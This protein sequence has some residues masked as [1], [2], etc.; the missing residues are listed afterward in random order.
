M[1]NSNSL[2]SNFSSSDENCVLKSVQGR[3]SIRTED[4]E[5]SERK[6]LVLPK[7][8]DRSI[9]EPRNYSSSYVNNLPSTSSRLNTI[10]EI[11]DGKRKLDN[12]N[13]DD[14]EDIGS[15]EDEE[16]E[17]DSILLSKSNSQLN[18]SDLE[19]DATS[20]YAPTPTPI[21]NVHNTRRINSET[22]L[23]ES[24]RRMSGFMGNRSKRFCA[25]TSE[26]SFASHL[27]T[28]KSLFSPKNNQNALSRQSFNSSLYGSNISLNSTNSRLF[29]ANSPFYN[30]KTMFGGASAYPVRD[31]NQHKI[32]RNPVQM[33]PSSSLS[34]SSINSATSDNTP[35]SN[36]AKRI[37]E[38]MNQF[39]TP[40]KE[41][42]CMGNNI[43]SIL[44]IPSLVQNRQ[45]FGEDELN[46]NRSIAL[47]R[48]S[49]PYSR[50]LNQ[51]KNRTQSPLNSSI[52]KPLQIPTMSQLLQM[53]RLQNN[54]ERVR[55]IANKSESFLNKNLEYKLPSVTEETL[56]SS[57]S[58]SYKI[59]NNITK[60]ILRS[61]KKVDHDEIPLLNLPNIQLPVMKSVPKFDIKLI[62]EKVTSTMTSNTNLSPITPLP[63][64]KFSY[65][66][67]LLT[68]TSNS[69]KTTNA[70][71]SNNQFNF[72]R[73]I[74]LDSH[75]MTNH[76]QL[77]SVQQTF[78]FSKPTTLNLDTRKTNVSA[79]V[80][81]EKPSTTNSDNLF[82]KLVAQQQ[83]QWECDACMSRNDSALLKC[84]SCETPKQGTQIQVA[85][86]GNSPESDDLFK[87][88]AAQQ[89][90]TNWECDSCMT[91]NDAN[92][93]KCMC[94][95]TPKPGSIV[96]SSIGVP[97]K[98][99]SFGMPK[100]NQ[101]DLF[102]NLA[103]KQKSTQWECDSCLTGNDA[104]KD[105]CLCCNAQKPGT[106]HSVAVAKTNS[107]SFGMP[108][109]KEIN[110]SPKFSFGVPSENVKKAA[111]DA[112]FKSLLVKQ[113]ANW[114]CTACFTRNDQLKLKCVCCEQQKP[115]SATETTSQFS[116]GSKSS[117]II[118]PVASEVKFSFGMPVVKTPVDPNK[119]SSG[120]VINN[121]VHTVDVSDGNIIAASIRNSIPA[122]PIPTFSFKTPTS[123]S[124]EDSA[125]FLFKTPVNDA[126]KDNVLKVMSQN[127]IENVL[128]AIQ[129]EKNNAV[130]DDEKRIFES[131]S[132]L[133]SDSKS[134]GTI[135]LVDDPIV[136]KLDS[137][138]F[139][140]GSKPTIPI[141]S[142]NKNGG[143]SFGS[144]TATSETPTKSSVAAITPQALPLNS[145]GFSFSSN[146]SPMPTKI[147][148]SPIVFGNNSLT[149]QLSKS[150]VGA[151]STITT[152]PTS[153]TFTFG[154][155]SKDTSEHSK[156]F[157]SYESSRS[158]GNT[159]AAKLTSFSSTQTNAFGKESNDTIFSFSNSKNSEP[160]TASA[161]TVGAF[162]FGGENKTS[163]PAAGNLMLFG[164]GNAQTTLQS[165]TPVFGANTASAIFG[166]YGATSAP[167]SNI[168]NNNE[169]GF[170][171]KMP[172]FGSSF[173]NTNNNP[174]QTNSRK[175]AF[176]F[177][178]SEDPS[179]KKKNPS[180]EF[181]SQSA[182]QPQQ[183]NTAP[184][185]FGVPRGENKPAFNFTAVPSF[186]FGN[187]VTTNVNS[188][189][190]Q[191]QSTNAPEPFQ[192]GAIPGPVQPGVQT[193]TSQTGNGAAQTARRK[194]RANRRLPPR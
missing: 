125:S 81:S 33:R 25:S 101:D 170:G 149:Q 69:L 185:Q 22:N 51:S 96:A 95:E 134:H 41:A 166:T 178:M 140:F 2:E 43:N 182:H 186:N 181:S 112:G 174:P 56:A 148:T 175:P 18:E 114:E 36:T 109:S 66:S 31:I 8:E 105:R 57:S 136:K 121:I 162:T 73:P 103:A 63:T 188:S 113:N 164:S 168:N 97:V 151:S 84:L 144:F 39:S 90:K 49:A 48:P 139:L 123:S 55:E 35:L 13:M 15:V 75:Q 124:N 159:D 127:S 85:V 79:T 119:A 156:T 71:K 50:P 179:A 68:T 177:G 165:V 7:H 163:E 126:P 180:F 64:V 92:K 143:F 91:Q 133:S 138:G 54:T 111:L 26:L 171:S 34:N 117:G 169:S 72:S 82:K 88:L 40:L 176:Q 99:F 193:F 150:N 102:K 45:R 135:A 108:T 23:N 74:A 4:F 189:D 167:I 154:G 20:S 86:T 28:H 107:F 46:L 98:T 58:S 187:N 1:R 6:N 116:F 37:L 110:E 142:L 132:I 155:G 83:V 24:Q 5:I 60:K 141:T 145:S 152:M 157:D 153:S 17:N 80:Q 161:S 100:T 192:F 10:K 130:F 129:F 67:S 42:R 89:K 29:M 147:T 190:V 76:S 27:D 118:L 173:G 21:H 65:G 9:S 128:P 3:R 19:I 32:L 104:S 61:D 131:K 14:A 94:C 59:K 44:K 77:K 191:L 12:N 38:V 106:T 115:G 87:S 93:E 158:Q 194:I 62:T 183:Q 47:S 30:G 53:K 78:V 160:P 137:S 120:E 146:N 184:F 16:E 172:S 70:V 11:I 52:V 122:S